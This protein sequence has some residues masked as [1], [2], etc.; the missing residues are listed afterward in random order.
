MK[1]VLLALDKFQDDKAGEF[2]VDLASKLDVEK[3]DIKIVANVVKTGKVAELAYARKIRKYDVAK[4]GVQALPDK[5]ADVA[6]VFG[7]KAKKLIED[8]FVV[9][10]KIE[11]T[12]KE[13]VK[14]VITKIEKLVEKEVVDK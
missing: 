4:K 8:R 9:E 6:V 2:A 11:L 13:K 10:E 1:A 7:D 12:G 3:F 14:G 5:T